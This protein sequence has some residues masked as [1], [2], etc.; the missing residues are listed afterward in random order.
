MAE[1][2]QC[3]NCSK[4][5]D[6]PAHALNKRFCCDRCRNQWHNSR[7]KAARELIAEQDRQEAKDQL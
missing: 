2:R 5:I 1:I 3:A 4:P 7:I 6:V